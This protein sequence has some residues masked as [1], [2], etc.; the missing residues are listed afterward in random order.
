MRA[1][2]LERQT[3]HKMPLSVDILFTIRIHLDPLAALK[4]RPGAVDE[5]IEQLR[6]LDAAELD[7]KG[8]RDQRYALIAAMDDP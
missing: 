1:R 6:E 8:L 3:L 7:Y 4:D 5:F 2:Q